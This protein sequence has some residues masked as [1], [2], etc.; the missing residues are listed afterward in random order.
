MEENTVG[1]EVMRIK[2][3][4]MDII[5]T[6]NWLAV[7]EIAS[8]NEGGYFSI[9]TDATTNEGIITV[10]KVK[11]SAFYLFLFLQMNILYNKVA[12]FQSVML[13]ASF[14]NPQALDYEEIK[15]LN[16]GIRVANKAGYDFGAS[17]SMTG[18]GAGKTYP[19]KINVLNQKEGP[20]F[21][22]TVKV[23]PVSEDKS[24]FSVTKVITTYSAIDSDTLKTA[25]NVR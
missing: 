11:S 14:F 5:Y 21:L 19:V 2:A 10:N 17:G 3:T 1:K 22:P 8:G 7:Y 9:T 16:L 6:D 18:A 20:R 15:A 12:Q 13:H 25:T 24:S 23:V 4:D